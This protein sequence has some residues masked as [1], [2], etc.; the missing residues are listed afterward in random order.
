[1]A[2]GWGPIGG[3]LYCDPKL[4]ELFDLTAELFDYEFKIFPFWTA[5]AAQDRMNGGVADHIASDAACDV[6][7]AG[8]PCM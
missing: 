8:F 6:P 5:G 7:G 4:P 2:C 3:F 1:M